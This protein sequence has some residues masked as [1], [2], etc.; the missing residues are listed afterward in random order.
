MSQKQRGGRRAGAGRK[1]EYA[2]PLERRTVTLPASYV[3][4]LTRIGCGNLSNGIRLVLEYGRA[5]A[6]FQLPEASAPDERRP[7]QRTPC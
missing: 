1:P 7:A 5:G 6:G 2:E 4:E 3:A